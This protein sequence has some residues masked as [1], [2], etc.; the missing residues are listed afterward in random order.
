MGQTLK[1]LQKASNFFPN[2]IILIGILLVIFPIFLSNYQKLSLFQNNSV[3]LNNYQPILEI[4]Q[5]IQIKGKVSKIPV[6]IGHF[7]KG[8]WELAEDKALY[9]SSSGRIG[10]K[11][12]VVIYGHNTY[13]IFGGLLN[14]KIGD[15]I[16]LT[17]NSG[18]NYKYS[19]YN[20]R[21]VSPNAV[22]ILS[23][24]G[25]ER[26]TLFTCDGLFDSERLVVEARRI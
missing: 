7:E 1:G 20:V 8:E 11:G 12:N 17:S 18:F 10:Q 25:D 14:T 23:Q 6:G 9:L 13:K 24:E 22:E 15:Q 3:Q 16:Q 26:I 19:V 2:L 21:K 4:P 5:Y